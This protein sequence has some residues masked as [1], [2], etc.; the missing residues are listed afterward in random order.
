[1]DLNPSDQVTEDTAQF[2]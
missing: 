2:N 1:M